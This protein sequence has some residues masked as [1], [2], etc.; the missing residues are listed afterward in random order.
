M[1]SIVSNLLAAVSAC[2]NR[3]T[4]AIE[5]EALSFDVV[6]QSV[7]SWIKPVAARVVVFHR[8]GDPVA[9]VKSFIEV[10]TNRNLPF[11]EVIDKKTSPWLQHSYALRKPMFAP[12]Q[13][14]FLRMRIADPVSSIV[15][16]KIKR[17]IR[18]NQV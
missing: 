14:V 2:G 5:L 9:E 7:M 1:P 11:R 3:N 16:S 8:Y 13:V 18:K 6:Q 12:I 10:G 4:H 15:F 17:R